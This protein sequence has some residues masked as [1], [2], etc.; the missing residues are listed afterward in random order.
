MLE[1]EAKEAREA[2]R[3][4]DRARAELEKSEAAARADVARLKAPPMKH[5]EAP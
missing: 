3:A 1:K 5:L 4:S 2:A